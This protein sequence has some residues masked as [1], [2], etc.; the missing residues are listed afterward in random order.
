MLFFNS[1]HNNIND[2]NLKKKKNLCSRFEVLLDLL[3]LSTGSARMYK[4]WY[5][6]HVQSFL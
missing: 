5:V 6:M 3:L 1:L 2:L 4:E